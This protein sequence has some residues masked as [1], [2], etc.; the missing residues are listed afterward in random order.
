M[1]RFG[2]IL[3]LGAC[4]TL[5]GCVGRQANPLLNAEATDVPGAAPALHAAEASPSNATE[6]TAT[7]YF[8]YGEQAYLAA[9]TRTLTV[10][11]DQTDE[12]ALV[13]ALL[14]GPSADCPALRALFP[15]SVRLLELS[16]SG[17]TLYVTFSAE[18][19]TGDGIPADWQQQPEWAEEAPLRRRLTM[20][21][22]ACTLTENTGYTAVQV[23]LRRDGDAQ[24][25]FRLERSYFLTGETGVTEPMARQESLLSTPRQTAIR[26]MEAWRDRDIDALHALIAEPGPSLLELAQRVDE[27]RDMAGYEASA[28]SVSPPLGRA[29]VSLTVETADAYGVIQRTESL[30]LQLTWE[31]GVWK[32]P[33]DALLWLL[34]K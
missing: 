7:L 29:V 4:L 26:V 16:A 23:L 17:E 3:C 9:E 27:A 33:Y 13:E 2:L 25:S 6:R 28:G 19:L 31:D 10:R 18:L 21:S 8:R 5:C 1:K 32:A 11:R 22:L 20:A 15:D 24:S 14:D 12:Q 34:T 30:P